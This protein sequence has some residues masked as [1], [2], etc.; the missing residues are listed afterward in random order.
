MPE[1]ANNKMGLIGVGVGEAY[2]HFRGG[3]A[4]GWKRKPYV[5]AQF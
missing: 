3:E 2:S 5:V 1:T 4:L